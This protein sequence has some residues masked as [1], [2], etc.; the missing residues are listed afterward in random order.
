[1]I[2]KMLAIGFALVASATS[3]CSP[4]EAEEQKVAVF[5]YVSA[6]PGKENEVKAFLLKIHKYMVDHNKLP[7]IEALAKRLRT[8][9]GG[10]MNISE[11]C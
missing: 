5:A 7:P 10:R 1:M 8:L 6:A 3:F 9:A 4:A 11:A 2:T